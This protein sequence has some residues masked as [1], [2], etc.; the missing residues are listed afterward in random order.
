[1]D[2]ASTILIYSITI[3][4]S[5]LAFYVAGRGEYK[6]TRMIGVFFAIAIT[7]TIAGIR[8]SIGSDYSS[9]IYGFE[10][11]QAGVNVRWAALEYGFY[12]LNLIL[13]RIGFDAQSIMF[14]CSLITMS[15]ITKALMLEKK[16]LSVGFGAL[17]FMLLFYQSTFNTIRLMIA[18]SIALYNISNIEKRKLLKFLVFSLLAASFHISALVTIPLFWL[19]PLQR[20]SKKKY[21]LF[22]GACLLLIFFNPILERLLALIDF[23]GINYYQQYIGSSSKSIEI[24]VKKAILYLPILIPGAFMYNKCIEQFKNFHTY[25]LMTFLGVVITALGT[26]RVVYVDR[27]SQYFL[28]AAIIVVPVYVRVFL[29]NKNYLLLIAT[30]LYLILFWIYVYFVVKD[31]GTVPY[32]W[33][34]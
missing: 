14:A 19:L 33:I 18:V 8:Y 15:F 1:M 26:F 5:S 34:L 22:A 10:R 32:Q 25:Y 16:Y 9:Y 24:A 11:I 7:V 17:V 28:I 29:K 6:L 21:L 12:F 30:V 13:A 2:L 20:N 3:L 4:T 23:E 27:I 31:H